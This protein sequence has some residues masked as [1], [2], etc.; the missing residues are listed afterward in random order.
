MKKTILSKL[1]FGFFLIT[2]T[3]CEEI[4]LETD[5]SK[6]EVQLVAP[7][8]NI[9]FNATGVTFTWEAV[10]D[11]TKYRLQIAKPSF[12]N[13]SQIV[14]DTTITATSFNQQLAIANY[15]WRVRALN[16]AYETNYSSRFF[17]VANNDDFQSN[18][19]VLN[20]P[21]N[22]LIT[23]TPLQSLSWQSIIGATNYQLQVYDSSN[24]IK[25]D[26][27]L[28]TTSYDYT[29]PE[30][31]YSWR[32]KATNGEKQTLYTSRTIL[33]DKTVPNT[34]TLVSPVNA[35]TTSNTT[36][37]FQWSRTAIPGSAEKDS[38]YI[39]TNS[40]ETALKLKAEATSPYSNTTLTTGT[41]YW[42]TKAFDAAG[43]TSAK[44]TVFSF[45]VN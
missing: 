8:N 20:T 35:S 43:N 6:K 10:P 24:T 12:E 1:F 28:T 26:E 3:S 11:A 45:T 5:I 39:Y 4:L 38:I 25:L 33:V 17:S 29:F 22:N 2:V 44:S 14:L 19:V 37:S 42:H 32:V 16:S 30:G 18:T 41:Y 9:S 13:P 15:E 36:I 34:P 23:K 31:N 27:T 21:S 40:T 7:A